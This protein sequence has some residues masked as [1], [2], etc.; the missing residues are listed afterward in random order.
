MTE[1]EARAWVRAHLGVSRET[2]LADFAARVTTENAHQNLIAAATV[3][4]IWQRHIV[5][6]A[7]LVRLADGAPE[8]DWID[9]GSGAGFPGMV[10]ALATER[11]VTLVEPRRRRA[12]FL[13]A[14]AESLGLGNRV[15]VV[16]KKVERIAPGR[17]AVISARAVAALPALF[18]AARHLSTPKTRWLLPKGRSAREEVAAAACAWHGV[19]H[20]EQSVTDSD[21]LIVIAEDVAPR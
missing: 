11:A 15:A 13:A 7:Q 6:S 1:D 10:V 9:I 18:S 20:V 4:H 2:A 16:A 12:E 3:A 21:A 17:A 8:G 19:F 5:D 14:A